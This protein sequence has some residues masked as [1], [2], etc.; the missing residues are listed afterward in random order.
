[1]AGL[2]DEE[3]KTFR[4]DFVSWLGTEPERLEI[5]GF[6]DRDGRR[7]VQARTRLQ[8]GWHTC[9]KFLGIS[10]R[11]VAR[12]ELLRNAGLPPDNIE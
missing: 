11:W 6:C 12:A 5:E 7:G 9:Y 10:P 8:G 4:V 3:Q 2:S 1:M